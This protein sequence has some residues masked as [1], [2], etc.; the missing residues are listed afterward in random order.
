MDR[1]KEEGK[2]GDWM[3]GGGGVDWRKEEA[4]GL[5]GEE[6]GKIGEVDWEKRW[7]E[8]RR[9]GKKRI[10]QGEGGRRR[11]SDRRRRKVTSLGI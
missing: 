5:Q 7:R 11:R 4:K 8:G 10:G 1:G 3:G 2:G 6:E 9:K